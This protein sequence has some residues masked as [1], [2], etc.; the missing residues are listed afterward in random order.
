MR[1]PRFARV[2]SL[3]RIGAPSAWLHWWRWAAQEAGGQGG[4]CDESVSECRRCEAPAIRIH[5]RRWRAGCQQRRACCGRAIRPS[6]PAGQASPLLRRRSL[7]VARAA[8]GAAGQRGPCGAAKRTTRRGRGGHRAAAT[9]PEGRCQ[10]TGRHSRQWQAV[11]RGG[12]GRCGPFPCA[13]GRAVG[14]G[15]SGFAGVGSVGRGFQA[16]PIRCQLPGRH[17]HRRQPV[18][19]LPVRKRVVGE[20]LAAQHRFQALRIRGD[21]VSP[22]GTE[23]RSLRR[24]RACTTAVSRMRN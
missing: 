20:R 22:R 3:F 1:N 15:W 18:R 13:G 5:R 8:V 24:Q 17:A 16:L 19:K 7:A 21:D 23:R 9:D 12:V 14:R 2:R 6:G 4:T 11:A 10:S